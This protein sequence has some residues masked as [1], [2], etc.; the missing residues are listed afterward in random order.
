M[1]SLKYLPL[2]LIACVNLS[3]LPV[4]AEETLKPSE[5]PAKH[6]VE[7]G[8]RKNELYDHE[9]AISDYKAALK[10]KPDYARAFFNLG[11]AACNTGDH[12][13]EV[14][15]FGKAFELDSTDFE[16]LIGRGMGYFKLGEIARAEEDFRE[17]LKLNPKEKQAYIWLGK[18][19]MHEGDYSAALKKFNRTIQIDPSFAPAYRERALAYR[20]ISRM[21]SGKFYSK[22]TISDYTQVI[23][24]HPED[25]ESYAEKASFYLEFGPLQPAISNYQQAADLLAKQDRK[26]ESSEMI[27]IVKALKENFKDIEESIY[28]ERLR[29]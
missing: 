28:A 18:V 2:I 16:A 17:S 14:R 12:H 25:A 4:K 7:R 13:G 29:E 3:I 19:A 6:L 9:G 11:V 24:L 22:E 5:L 23:K 21:F 1:R 27:E 20:Q 8:N 10:I 26:V 15:Y